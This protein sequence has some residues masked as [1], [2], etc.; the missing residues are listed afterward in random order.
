MRTLNA[1]ALLSPARV[2]TLRLTDRL[3]SAGLAKLV[4]SVPF[5]L[6]TI[7][8]GIVSGVFQSWGSML[9]PILQA[10]NTATEPPCHRVATT[11]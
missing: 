1:C 10:S 9:G 7:S 8:F 3:P 4:R 5:W 11:V 2:A 6:L